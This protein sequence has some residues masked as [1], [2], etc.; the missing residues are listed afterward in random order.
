[1]ETKT[2]RKCQRVLN[3]NDFGT[4]ARYKDGHLAQ[5]KQCVKEYMREYR[6]KNPE[7]D[8]KDLEHKREYRKTDLY[9]LRTFQN[10]TQ[11]CVERGIIPPN[12]FYIPKPCSSS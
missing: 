8:Q 3:L 9:Q 4:S 6:E 11:R 7:Y 12:Q 10:A 1:M 5:C 2:C